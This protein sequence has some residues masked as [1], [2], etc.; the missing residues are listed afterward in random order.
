MLWII[1]LGDQFVFIGS[2][3]FNIFLIFLNY[4]G[5]PKLRGDYVDILD[6]YKDWSENLIKK[7]EER[8]KL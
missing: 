3:L 4:R 6:R 8:K 7:D 1:R 2:C 5:V